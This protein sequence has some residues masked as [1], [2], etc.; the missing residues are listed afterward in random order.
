[1]RSKMLLGFGLCLVICAF[2]LPGY[3]YCSDRAFLDQKVGACPCYPLWEIQSGDA[4]VQWAEICY[5][6]QKWGTLKGVPVPL[7]CLPGA[8]WDF[9]CDGET[10]YKS[11]GSPM[12]ED[13]G[14]DWTAPCATRGMG[15]CHMA[16]GGLCVGDPGTFISCGDKPDV[17]HCP[18]P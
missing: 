6:Y 3:S 4:C 8:H 9:G 18:G 1:M 15:D 5:D 16:I 13:G 12:V 10:R 17:R 7:G 2:I 14:E 11:T